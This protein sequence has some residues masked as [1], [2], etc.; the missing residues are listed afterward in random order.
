M[1][2]ICTL[3]NGRTNPK[4]TLRKKISTFNRTIEKR[5]NVRKTC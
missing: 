3:I 5:E 2:N 1:N 4:C